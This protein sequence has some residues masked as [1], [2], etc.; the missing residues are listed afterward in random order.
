MRDE[1]NEGR[2]RG[3]KAPRRDLLFDAPALGQV[4]IRLKTLPDVK[5][6]PVRTLL[7]LLA[8]STQS[9]YEFGFH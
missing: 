5:S 9:Q 4:F 6:A 2:E 1:R 8:T 7:E 3:R